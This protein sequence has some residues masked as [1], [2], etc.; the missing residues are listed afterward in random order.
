MYKRVMAAVAAV[1]FVLLAFLAIIITDL[2]DRDF[3]H[4]IGVESRVRLDFSESGLSITEAFST[5]E[6][7]DARCS[8]G[9]VKVAP[10]LDSDGSGQVFVA[11]DGDDLPAEFTWFAGDEVSEIVGKER[12]ANSYP[13][14]TYLV[15][16]QNAQLDNALQELKNS[17]VKVGRW[18]ASVFDSLKFVVY[19]RG[20][21]AAVLAV[22]AL[23][24]ALAL[25]WLSVKARG[26]A[27]RV[28]GGCPTVWI[29][30]QDL[31][32][33]GGALLVSAGAVASIAT[34]YVGVLHGWVYVSTFL[35]VLLVLQLTVVALALL[36]ALVMSATAWPSATMLATRQPAIKSLRSAAI[37]LQ[38]ITFL[39]VVTAAGPAW[40][41]YK[42]S[43]AVAVEM[44]QWQQLSD[45]VAIEFGMGNL[46]G[47]DGMVALEPQ[48]GEMVKDAESLDM[49]A[50]SYTFTQE[51]WTW[52]DTGET[53]D[54]G[55]YSAVSFVNQR[56]LDLVTQEASNPALTS[57]SDHSITEELHQEIQETAELL[58]REE[59]TEVFSQFK[60]LEPADGFR[61]PV[62]E[63]GG[64]RLLFADDVLIVVVPSLYDTYSDS[65]LTSMASTSNIV[66]TDVTA[67]QQ[68]LEQ[69]DLSKQALRERGFSGKL[70]VVY[71]AEE[72][73]L[74]AQFAAYIVWLR[75]LALVALGVAFIVST[76]ISASITA[77]LQAKRDFPLRLAGQSWMGILQG[78]IIKELLV[79]GVLV[80]IVI[81]FQRPESV[82]PI[83]VATMFG[84]IVVPLSH[85]LAT[86]WCFDGVAR[87]RI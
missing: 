25:F 60:Y 37:A 21:A 8:L 47:R 33:F 1:L 81:L 84:L 54:F 35:K 50:H 62:A 5:I 78:R 69:H 40:S 51:M 67:T 86:R 6:E 83:L 68:L 58:S 16:S 82:G 59:N 27:L 13:D 38:V 24:V 56:W 4:A 52:V 80:G 19:E 39:L 55:E 2:H 53:V 12:L 34:V 31:T 57:V 71:I 49:V 61:L 20:F 9:L 45:Q 15:T 48:I 74:R 79:G 32:G 18:D 72:G 23:L 46:D 64:N 17:G 73:L 63:G 10:E 29:Q 36:A 43:S 11:F 28:L 75:I 42:Y 85:M 44:A 7:L 87:R 41:A 70:N 66:F 22:L 14:G 76:G 26:R 30:V 77:L 65:N 3:P